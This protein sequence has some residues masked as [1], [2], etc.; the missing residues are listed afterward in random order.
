MAFGQNIVDCNGGVVFENKFVC[1]C[2]GSSSINPRYK[3]KNARFQ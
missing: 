3:F 1:P 2:Y